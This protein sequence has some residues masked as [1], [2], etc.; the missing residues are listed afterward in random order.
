MSELLD[1]L[2]RKVMISMFVG[3]LEVAVAPVE[4]LHL[5]LFIILGY[6]QIN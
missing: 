1:F 2:D 4:V 3:L 5:L 6:N